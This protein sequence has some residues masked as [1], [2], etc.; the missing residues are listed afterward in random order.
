MENVDFWSFFLYY[1]YKLNKCYIAYYYS[2]DEGQFPAMTRPLKS[3]DLFA[4][5]GGLTCGL[6]QSGVAKC[7][8]AVESNSEAAQAFKINN[9]GKQTCGI[10]EIFSGYEMVTHY[11]LKHT[12]I[13]GC[14]IDST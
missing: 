6:E 13:R 8:W 3:L 4:G 10:T 1:N 2:V 9:K 11:H 14:I 7:H 5:A 12:V